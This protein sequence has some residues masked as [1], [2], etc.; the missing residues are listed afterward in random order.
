MKLASLTEKN[1]KLEEAAKYREEANQNF[2]KQAEQKLNHKMVTNK[3]NKVALLNSLMD[4][5]K[6]TVCG[7]LIHFVLLL[8]FILLIVLQN[9]FD[10]VY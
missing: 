3:E 8:L 2:S 4:R 7:F 6:K 1:Q 5:L 9:I 10:L